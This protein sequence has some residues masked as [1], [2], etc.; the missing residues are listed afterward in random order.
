[1]SLKKKLKKVGKAAAFAGAAYLASKAMAGKGSSKFL[2]SGAAGGARLPKGDRMAR[3]KKLMTSNMS[4]KGVITPKSKPDTSIMGKIGAATNKFVKSAGDATKK[5][6]KQ[7]VNLKRGPNIKKT[8]SLASSVLSGE[9]FGL[10]DMDGAKA[11]GMMYASSGKYVKAKCKLG[12]N[13]KT[14][15][16]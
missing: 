7:N 8:D 15:I 4:Y 10:G 12:R 16:T 14:L 9:V 5:V 1:M 13:K 2:S 3:A 11:G 6:I